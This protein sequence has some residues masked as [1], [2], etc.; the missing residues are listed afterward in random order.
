MK[1][2]LKILLVIILILALINALWVSYD[3][4]REIKN[5]NELL[6]EEIK[7]N[8]EIIAKVYKHL[9]KLN[10]KIDKNFNDL[11]QQINNVSEKERLTKINLEYKLRQ[12]VVIILNKTKGGLGSGVTIK[13]NDK[14]YILSA[15]HMADSKEDILTFGENDNELGE[16][17]IIKH[18]FIT[19]ED[20]SQGTDLLLLRPKNKNLVPKYY[21]EL[22]DFE[23][24]PP[25][26]IYIVG[27]PAAIE[28]VLCEGRIIIYHNNYCYYINHTYFGNSGG[29]IFTKDGRLL[30]IISHMYPINLSPA[31]PPYMTYGAVRLNVIRDFLQNIDNNYR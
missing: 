12:A 3:I 11:N 25:T 8:D 28:D 19:P 21:I 29:G 24:Q 4:S 17:E 22:A 7:T 26:E 16:L 14:F 5:N 30:G 31:I 27:N 10:I 15:G 1:L 23:A 6:Q 9:N 18:D 20:Y 2:S 13:Y